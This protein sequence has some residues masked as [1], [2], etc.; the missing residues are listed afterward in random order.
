MFFKLIITP[1]T[2]HKLFSQLYGLFGPYNK[3]IA[4]AAISKGALLV[5]NN[6]ACPNDNFDFLAKDG[7]HP[8]QQG[9]ILI[10][11][12]W[13]PALELL[14]YP[15]SVQKTAFY[16]VFSISYYT[17]PDIPLFKKSTPPFNTV[18]DSLI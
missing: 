12:T 4:Y 2:S 13:L 7:L 16:Q 14:I 5:D 1:H 11:R 8:N 10:S 15:S 9:N 6:V 17:N 3:S 18:L